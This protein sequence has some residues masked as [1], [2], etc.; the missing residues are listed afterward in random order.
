MRPLR[1]F[2]F[3]LLSSYI[4]LQYSLVTVKFR[5]YSHGFVMGSVVFLSLCNLHV[6]S[7][8]SCLSGCHWTA[9]SVCVS[10]YN[11]NI[12]ISYC[13]CSDAMFESLSMFLWR[14]CKMHYVKFL[15]YSSTRVDDGYQT[16]VVIAIFQSGCYLD[17]CWGLWTHW[18]HLNEK[19]VAEM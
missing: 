13:W 2:E 9:C 6:K 7:I 1:F 12:Y 4:L 3:L 11:S 5:I 18:Q 19:Y 8:T 17:L 10:E 16:F 15:Y 14:M